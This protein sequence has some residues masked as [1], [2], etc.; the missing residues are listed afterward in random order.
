M[1]DFHQ[2][3]VITT[4]HRLGHDGV[5]RLEQELQRL[6]TELLAMREEGRQA[7]ADTALAVK[8]AERA[9]TMARRIQPNLA[10]GTGS[11]PTA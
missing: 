11:S 5:G 7:E 1:A 3:G 8:A 4:L 9:A 10:Q 6:R 2:S